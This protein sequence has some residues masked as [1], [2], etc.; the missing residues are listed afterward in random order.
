VIDLLAGF[1]QWSDDHAERVRAVREQSKQKAKERMRR[2][3]N[4]G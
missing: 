2:L 3:T 4:D 1:G